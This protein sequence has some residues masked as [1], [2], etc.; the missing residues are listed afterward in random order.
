MFAFG[1]C[2]VVRTRLEGFTFACAAGSM[3]RVRTKT[4]KKLA[5]VIRQCDCFLCIEAQTS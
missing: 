2:L 1:F 3:G 5:R 4:V